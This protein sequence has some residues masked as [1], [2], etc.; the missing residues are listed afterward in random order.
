MSRARTFFAA[1]AAAAC[2]WSPSWAAEPTG[3]APSAGQPS[4][5]D[6]GVRGRRSEDLH[7]TQAYRDVIGIVSGDSCK[8]TGG[9]IQEEAKGECPGDKVCVL[10]QRDKGSTN[11]WEQG[12]NPARRLPTKEYRADCTKP[13]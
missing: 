10:Q 12:D 9:K 1:L 4:D 11:S 8:L 3:P 6:A 2:L 7:G 5:D 13:T